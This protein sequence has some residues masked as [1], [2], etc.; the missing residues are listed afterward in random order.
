MSRLAKKS[1]QIPEKV[2][3]EVKA[4]VFS[5][6]G[7]LGELSIKMSPKISIEINE[8]G[9]KVSKIDSDVQSA[10][11]VGTF[12]SHVMNMIEGVSKGYTKK[13]VI[14]GIGFKA[15][16][17]ATDIT[18]SLG[19]SH[20]IK[21]VIPEGIKVVSEKNTLIITG[22]SKDV[23]GQFAAHVR[24]QRKPEPYKGK[25]IRYDTEVIRRKQ[26]KKTV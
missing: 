22:I 19:F 2:T 7:P 26:G 13:L 11:L 14:D 16:V 15:D 8:D 25:G 23:V 5:V 12:A 1:I 18:L 3:A 17:K 6:K 21:I 9:I 20:T 10:A 24:S 4:N